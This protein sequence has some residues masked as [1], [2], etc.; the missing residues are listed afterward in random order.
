MLSILGYFDS[1][2]KF[3]LS[4]V[5]TSNEKQIMD[6]SAFVFW[7]KNCSAFSSTLF[8]TENDEEGNIILYTPY[9]IIIK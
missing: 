2:T 3:K 7:I 9:W 5:L 4:F 1:L 8:F 6:C